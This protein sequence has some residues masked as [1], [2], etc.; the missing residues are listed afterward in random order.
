MSV[1][2]KTYKVKVQ[3]FHTLGLD[4]SEAM[5]TSKLSSTVK[6]EM[7]SG[8]I[9]MDKMFVERTMQDKFFVVQRV[10]ME[11]SGSRQV[12][13]L[14]HHAFTVSMSHS[15]YNKSCCLQPIQDQRINTQNSICK[16]HL[17][18]SA[19]LMDSPKHRIC[20]LKYCPVF[21]ATLSIHFASL[22]M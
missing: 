8:L 7:K 19:N 6:R 18:V 17:S 14:H 5:D 4:S 15:K 10:W 3:Q 12:T 13:T 20:Y 9:G 21:P 22:F 11:L 1:K 2:A 16:L